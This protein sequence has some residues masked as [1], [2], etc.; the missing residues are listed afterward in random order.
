[1]QKK[2]QRIFDF[3]NI[4]H[5]DWL[6]QNWNWK[7]LEIFTDCSKEYLNKNVRDLTYIF[8]LFIDV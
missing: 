5:F 4:E 2:K 3:S 7:R 6:E 1:M 8:G